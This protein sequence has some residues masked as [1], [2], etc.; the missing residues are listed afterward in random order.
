MATA[1]HNDGRRKRKIREMEDEEME[2]S[3][4]VVAEGDNNTK[5][6]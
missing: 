5:F 6:F 2:G 4:T 1:T 3:K